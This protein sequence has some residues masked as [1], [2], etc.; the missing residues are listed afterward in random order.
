MKYI[1]VVIAILVLS[2]GGNAQDVWLHPNAGQWDDRVEYK[3]EL[4]LGEMLVEKDKFTYHLTDLKLGHQ[5]DDPD[6]SHLDHA[7]DPIRFHVIQT[8]FLNSNWQGQS[9]RE[10]QSG[11]YRNYI[12][13]N[14]PS[15]WQSKLYSYQKV[16]M[17]DYYPGIDMILDGSNEQ[18]KYS[19]RVQPGIDANIIEMRYD[20]QD[21]LSI[22]KDG[23]LRI[24]NRF[25][26]II[27]GTPEAWL[28]E[29]GANVEIEFEITGN[30]VRFVMPNGYDSNE[31][32][33]ID[34]TLVFSSFT[35]A[36]ADNWGMTATPDSQG[37]LFAGG[38]IFGLGYPITPG[39]YQTGNNS[40]G[41]L[42]DR[43]TDV[44]ITKFT[45]RKSVV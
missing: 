32:L 30:T 38:I 42:T 14:N 35:G 25:G 28:E 10:I 15:K 36:S 16:T 27:E 40:Q 3:V 4:D 6:H 17:N 12:L 44:G 45:D 7:D 43:Y 18:L 13:G 23:S 37:A 8:T 21:V 22:A 26:E 9:T 20:G 33:I 5:H 1:S 34:P 24:A 31:T 11:H 29:S 39:A 41:T 19:F 2:F